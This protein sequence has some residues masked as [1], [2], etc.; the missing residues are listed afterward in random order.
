[1][2]RVILNYFVLKL[3]FSKVLHQI[4]TRNHIEKSEKFI[5][6]DNKKKFLIIFIHYKF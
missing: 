4:L 6:E 2:K 5:I 3:L 1:M